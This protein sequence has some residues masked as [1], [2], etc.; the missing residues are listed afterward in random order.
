M[1][2]IGEF[3]KISGL[4]IKTLRLYH[5]KEILI[6][7]KIDSQTGYRFYSST[8]AKKVRSII[9]L[10]NLGF[11]LNDIKQIL[12]NYN[13][14][15]D[16]LD[17]LESKNDYINQKIKDLE[18][19][20]KIM[21]QIIKTEKE[22]RMVNDKNKFEV[23]EKTLDKILIAGVRMKGRYEECGT[24]FSKIGKKFGRHICGKPLTLYYDGEYKENDADFE[25]SMP[26]KKGKGDDEISVREL[27]GGK[28]ISLIHKGPYNELGRS[29]EVIIKYVKDKGYKTKLPSR[30][31]YIKGPG[32][33]FKG[34]PKNYITE[35]QFMLDK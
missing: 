31:V 10:K 27:E 13:D 20:A 22:A 35:L 2:S 29:Y 1:F 28:C 9:Q 8:C 34:N 33:I 26:V 21:K 11:S 17:F 12:E 3:S 5:E 32:I 7:N 23:E 6:P 30:E 14:D 24:A 16:I 19:S 18:N 4:T 25:P 15:T